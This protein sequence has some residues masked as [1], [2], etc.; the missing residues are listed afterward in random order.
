MKKT[1]H[2]GLMLSL[3]LAISISSCKPKRQLIQITSPVEEK[4][5]SELFNDITNNELPF[6]TF[7]SKLNITITSGMRS[8]SSKANLKIIRDKQLQMSIQPLFGVEMIRLYIDVDTLLLIDRM[9]KRYVKEALLDLKKYYPVGFDY[10]TIEALLTNRLFISGRDQI[11]LKD[12]KKFDV[13]FSPEY[14]L[15]KSSDPDS[16]LEYSFMVNAGDNISFTQ[17]LDDTKKFSM[18]WSYNDFARLQSKVFPYTMNVEASTA[19]KKISTILSFSDI[20]LDQPIDLST[21]IPRG[22]APVALPDIL[23]MITSANI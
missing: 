11:E 8:L 10:H 4:N 19:N 9:N 22:Y 13:S 12:F 7:S 17:L 21:N 15:L 6:S 1:F 5:I 2:I 23:K 20:V 3:I 14:Y 18:K 16:G